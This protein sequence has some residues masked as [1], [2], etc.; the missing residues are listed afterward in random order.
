[1][2]LSIFKCTDLFIKQVISVNAGLLSFRHLVTK[3]RTIPIKIQHNF[4]FM[5]VED[6]FNHIF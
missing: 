6:S 2:I 4:S 3:S 1:M 5:F